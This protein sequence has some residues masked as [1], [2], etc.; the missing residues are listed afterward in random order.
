MRRPNN[1]SHLINLFFMTNRSLHK[2]MQ[3][4]KVIS[5]FSF[6]QFITIKFIREEEP[7]SMKDIARFISITPASATSLVHGLVQT[8]ALERIADNHDRRIV[9]L[10]TTPYG[11]KILR[12]SENN[13][14]KE[15][16][17]V[18]MKLSNGDRDNLI[19]VLEKLFALLS[20]ESPSAPRSK[21]DSMIR[22]S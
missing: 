13:V 19:S 8:G 17:R 20:S 15:L 21:T 3:D 2:H 16:K 10:R 9:R 11:K 4:K 18:F 6:L 22:S 7:V 5:S 12:D 1:I 14:K